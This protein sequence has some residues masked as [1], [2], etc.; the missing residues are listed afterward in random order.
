M[1]LRLASRVALW[2][3]AWLLIAQAWM[4]TA[5][6]SAFDSRVPWGLLTCGLAV[7]AG[8]LGAFL[9]A[10][11]RPDRFAR[12]DADRHGLSLLALGLCAQA[13]SHV[14]ADMSIR[15]IREEIPPIFGWLYPTLAGLTPLLLARTGDRPVGRQALLLSVF[16]TSMGGA[17]FLLDPAAAAGLGLVS[18]LLVLAEVGPPERL[19]RLLL[20]AGLFIALAGLATAR[21]HSLLAALPSLIWILGLGSLGLA[22]GLAGGGE[23]RWRDLLASAVLGGVIVALCGVLLTTWLGRNLEWHSALATRL[24]LFRQH[25]NFLAP[26]FGENAVLAL[27]LALRRTRAAPLWLGAAGLLAASTF[28]TDSRTGIASMLAGAALIPLC[29]LLAALLRRVSGRI[30]LAVLVLLPLLGAGAWFVAGGE[31]ATARVTAGLDRFEK[32]MEF[33]VDAWRNSLQVVSQHPWLG[34]GPHTFIAVERFRPGSRFYNEPESPHPHNVLLYVAQAAGL[35]ALAVVLV[36][37]GWFVV[38]SW[39]LFRGGS[40]PGALPAAVLAAAVTAVLA[41]LF[42]LGLS[43]DSVVPAPIFVLT[44][45][46]AAGR[47]PSGLP[48]LRPPRPAWTTAWAVVLLIFGVRFAMQPLRAATLST[49]AQ[50]MSWESQL[51]DGRAARQADAR[52][53]MQA[54]LAAWAPTP[55]AHDLLSRWLEQDGQFNEAVNVLLQLVRL[56]PRDATSHSL[57]GHLYMRVQNYQKAADELTLALQDIHGSAQEDK[58]R[59]DRVLCLAKLGRRD[60]AQ[61]ALVE[62]LALDS[63]VIALLPWQD[64]EHGVFRLPVTGTP[65]VPPIALVDAA[66]TLFQRRQADQAA[67]RAVDRRSWLDTYRAFRVAR[68]D[69]LAL[70]VLDWMDKNLPPGTIEPGTLASER[71]SIA[72]DGKDWDTAVTSFQ[73]ALDA[74]GNPFFR[75]RV[76]QAR[77]GRGESVDSSDLAQTA[78]AASGEILDQPTAFRDNLNAQ[79]QMQLGRGQPLA[80]A[81]DLRRTLLFE[82]DLLARAK[83]LL[84]VAELQSQGGRPDLCVATLRDACAHLAAKPFPWQALQDGPSSTLPGRIAELLWES[85]RKLGYDHNGRLHEAWGLPSFFSARQGPSLLRLAF[86]QRNAQVDQLLREADMQVLSDP[87]DLPALWARLFALEAAGQHLELET[88]MRTIVEEYAKTGVSVER[89]FK[90]L[91]EEMDKVASDPQAFQ[92]M[93]ADPQNWERLGFLSLLKGSYDLAVDFYGN[94]VEAARADVP[95]AVRLSGWQ[96]MAAFLH[97][98]PE[99]ARRILQAA[100]KLAP[101]D[102]MLQQR[103][104]VIPEGE[105]PK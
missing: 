20:P 65:G 88:A 55:K 11:W 34:I 9:L 38:R 36:W 105:L 99:D 4:S 25:P 66:T 10:R 98:Q 13:L 62:A 71:G 8:T 17:I 76:A 83:I 70:G 93:A 68:R 60:D 82:D 56:A 51:S 32:S 46:L 23:R 39:K 94:A 53:T 43:L 7:A 12:P 84:R 86:Y 15:A 22:A 44:G 30:V 3:L 31:R 57:L 69:D 28:M 100:A 80:A 85:W 5:S 79:V 26:F 75:Q 101:D 103:L 21:G 24:V 6:A 95:Q 54:A 89:Q 67:G 49:Q 27:G 96:A 29:W 14:G 41:G 48:R 50:L 72:L 77:A 52:A 87:H 19:D 58:D 42:D 97:R 18:L 33:R 73:Q 45:L 47:E 37:L 78:M 40:L 74:T 59:A 81:E 90:A 102:E 91:A 64:A 104:R 1:I 2:G 16:A 61:A 35:P 92:R 63:G